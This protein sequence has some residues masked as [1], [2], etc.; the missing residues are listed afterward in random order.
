MNRKAILD[1]DIGNTRLKWRYTARDGTISAGAVAHAECRLDRLPGQAPLRIRVASVVGSEWLEGLLASCRQ[2]WGA[3]PEIAQVVENCGGVRQGYADKSR[4]GVDRWLA[5]LAAHGATDRSCV[6]VS[7]GTAI[8]V[9]LLTA[10]GEHRGGYIV[11][12]LELMRSA[13]FAATNAVKLDRIEPPDN[14]APGRD[15]VPAVNHGLVLM[16]KG[17]VDNAVAE[18]RNHGVAPTIV[19]TGGDGEVLLPFLMKPFS[20]TNA[21]YNPTLVLD[22]LALALP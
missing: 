6:V 13:L 20:S 2:Q 21:I 15:T 8:T 18:L 22:G 9:D 16:V 12:G 4:L 3:E 19:L 5:M 1:F 7:C 11:P 14:L 10:T 17:L